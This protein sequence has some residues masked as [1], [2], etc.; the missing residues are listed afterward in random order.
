MDAVRRKLRLV[1][2]FLSLWVVGCHVATDPADVNLAGCWAKQIE[3]AGSAL[4]F[5]L[6][7]AD[8]TISGTGTF[9]IEAGRN[10]T[11]VVS[12]RRSGKD[13]WLTLNYDFGYVWPLD[14]TILSDN[15]FTAHPSTDPTSTADFR[16][17]P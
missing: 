13:L 17:C 7:E 4:S 11:L 12:G 5:T 10:G 8:G 1:P 15:W 9:A 3:I 2:A 16:R 14:A 6:S